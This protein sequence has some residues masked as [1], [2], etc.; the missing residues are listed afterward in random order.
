[1]RDANHTSSHYKDQPARTLETD[2]LRAQ[3]IPG[4]GAKLA[5]LVYKPRDFELLVQRP[6]PVYKLQL[7]DGDYV[8]GECSGLDDMFP[9]I[10]ACYYD[11]S[12]WQ[13]VKMADHGEVWSL[14]WETQAQED[15]LYFGVDGVR[16]PYRL[17]KLVSF[18]RPNTLRLDYTLTNRAPFD[19]EYVWAAHMMVNLEAGAEL[20]LPPGVSHMAHTFS[21]GAPLGPYGRI[22]D[23]PL[24]TLD[25]GSTLDLRRMRPKDTRQAYKYYIAGR[26]PEGWCSLSFPRSGFTLSLGFP[27]EQVPY[28]GV[29][30]NEG[31][32]QELYNLFLEPCSATFD[33]PDAARYRG[34][35]S[36]I[37]GGTTQEWYLEI[38]CQEN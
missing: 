21:M 14:N 34:E 5:S 16:F 22:Y 32:W 37:P 7:F 12:P 30:P 20:T 9:T 15:C 10:D 29:L 1:M 38:T 28:L 24:A 31:G 11:S 19:F 27:T 8:A 3:F 35:N 17:E 4:Q 25:D 13:G 36:V 2:L 18:P 26:L 33:R 6:D 23:W